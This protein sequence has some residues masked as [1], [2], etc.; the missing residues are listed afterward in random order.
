MWPAIIRSRMR[1][2]GRMPSSR[3]TW[4]S[5]LMSSPKAAMTAAPKARVSATC[6]ALRVSAA[7]PADRNRTP[8][9]CVTISRKSWPP[10]TM[11]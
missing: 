1:A 2:P 5:R 8:V 10:L 3:A 4:D 6:R 9:Q 11:P 7:V